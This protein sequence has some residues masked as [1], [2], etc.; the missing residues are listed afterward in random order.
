MNI[1]RIARWAPVIGLIAGIFASL[2]PAAAAADAGS[3]PRAKHVI[4]VGVAG[5][6]WQDV[7]TATTPTLARLAEHGSVGTMSARTVPAVACPGE[8]W[9]TLG[10][11]SLSAFRQPKD[12]PDGDSCAGREPARVE[13]GREPADPAK[14]P[15]PPGRVSDAERLRVLN[16]ALQ[17]DAHVGLLGDSV[18]CVSAVGRGAALAGA[19]RKGWVDHYLERL[20]TDPGAVL[21]RCPLTLVSMRPLP[22]GDRKQRLAQLARLDTALAAIVQHR[23][24]NTVLMVAGV[25]Q[26]ENTRARLQLAL[27]SGPGF[28]GGWLHSPSTRRVPY[29][30]L[31]DMAPTIMNLLGDTPEYDPAGQA[32][33]GEAPG[34]PGSLA[35]TKAQL[36]D[37]ERHALAQKDAQVWYLIGF[38]VLCGA[39][40]VPSGV[41]FF[42]RRRG[43]SFSDRALRIA[44][45]AAVTLS[46]VPVA[47]SLANLVPWWRAGWPLLAAAAVAVAIAG[48][49]TAVIYAARLRVGERH[50]ATVAV[51]AVA[52]VTVAVFVTD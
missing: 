3:T 51:V 21:Q 14:D 7:S 5:L 43:L 38:G 8:G 45:V 52:G 1:R 2:S 25:S 37:I 24:A 23:P 34:R 19:D 28:S 47:S 29:V 44:A 22:E 36:I 41:L 46:A 39:V 17:F 40:A 16:H 31:V 12:I 18:D 26:T 10:D 42:R 9:L 20:P 32:W 15:A 48:A 33:R 13:H 35:G 50:R 30:E 6:R 49:I 27:A 11:G 4:V